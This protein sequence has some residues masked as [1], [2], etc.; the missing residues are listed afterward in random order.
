MLNNK[1]WSGQL[2]HKW[3]TFL[4]EN[5]WRH[6]RSGRTSSIIRG[7]GLAGLPLWLSSYVDGDRPILGTHEGESTKYK[8]QSLPCCGL[9]SVACN[10]SGSLKWEMPS[11]TVEWSWSVYPAAVSVSKHYRLLIYSQI[12]K[13]AIFSSKELYELQR[14]CTL[15]TAYIRVSTF[16]D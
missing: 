5:Q 8:S 1:C 3:L 2:N 13:K 10:V 12:C 4:L 11:A 16:H 7:E 9:L 15:E 14:T 6:F